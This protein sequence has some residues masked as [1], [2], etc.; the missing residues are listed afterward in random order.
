MKILFC[1]IFALP[2]LQFDDKKILLYYNNLKRNEALMSISIYIQWWCWIYLGGV[3]L[4]A[5]CII[6]YCIIDGDRGSDMFVWD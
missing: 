3:W 5:F 2:G 4:L 6:G 1:P